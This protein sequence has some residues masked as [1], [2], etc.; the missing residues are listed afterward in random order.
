MKI[1]KITFYLTDNKY[2]FFPKIQ[3]I[4]FNDY[5]NKLQSLQFIPEMLFLFNL[6]QYYKF[7]NLRIFS[8]NNFFFIVVN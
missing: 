6:L 2:L 4:S 8:L 3:I 1:E 5:F 7:L